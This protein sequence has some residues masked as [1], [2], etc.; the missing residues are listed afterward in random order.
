MAAVL[1]HGAEAVASHRTAA[2][3]WDLLPHRG[4]AVYVTVPASGRAKRQGIVL[5]QVRALHERDRAMRSGIAVTA[6]ARTLIDVFGT[7]SEERRERALEQAERIGMLDGRALDEAC[8][9]APNRRGVKAVR[10]RLREHR[11]PAISRS[12]LERRFL[13]FCR[14]YKLP[15]PEMNAW[16]EGY[17]LDAVWR[18]QKVA[19]ELDD[20]YTHGTRGS[21]EGD[22]ERDMKLQSVGWRIPR[23]TA[24]RLKAEPAAIAGELRLLLSP[25]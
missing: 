12:A 20:F 9:R 11:A 25:P 21:F 16:V 24:K 19:V 23:V 2:A 1:L 4:N 13:I 7:E 6:L 3:L 5:E 14:E 8:Q 18:G 17:E 15:T 22:R 10:A